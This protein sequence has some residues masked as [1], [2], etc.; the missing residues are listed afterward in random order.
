LEL[1]KG[2][3]QMLWGSGLRSLDGRRYGY[4]VRADSNVW[5]L[6]VSA[7]RFGLSLR[8]GQSKFG[9]YIKKI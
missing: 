6:V 8:L 4:A 2:N 1:I 9:N 5:V 3:I 7:P